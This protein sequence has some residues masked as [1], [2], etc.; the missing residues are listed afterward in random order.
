MDEMSR[1]NHIFVVLMAK[2]DALLRDL[3]IQRTT[4]ILFGGDRQVGAMCR[5]G[6]RDQENFRPIREALIAL[7]NRKLSKAAIQ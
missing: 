3:T 1:V 7:S 4:R 2:G 6:V 5:H